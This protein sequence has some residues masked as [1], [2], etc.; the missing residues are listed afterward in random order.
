MRLTFPDFGSDIV[1]PI[2]KRYPI[3]AS[4]VAF[5]ESKLLT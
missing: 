2:C 5:G 3:R 1:L 4:A